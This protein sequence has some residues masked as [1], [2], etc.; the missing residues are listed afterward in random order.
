MVSVA[1]ISSPIKYPVVS[2][3][4]AQR[5][6]LSQARINMNRSMEGHILGPMPVHQ[7]LNDFLPLAANAPEQRSTR[8]KS[9]LFNLKAMP[10]VSLESEMYAPFI[11]IITKNKLIPGFKMVDTSNYVDLTSVNERRIKPDA[12]VYKIEVDTSKEKTQF[13]ELELHFELKPDDSSDPFR[14]PPKNVVDRRKWEFDRPTSDRRKNCRSQ[15]IHYV[16]DWSAHQ[17]RLFAFTVFLFDPYIRFIRWDRAGAIVSE[18]FNFRKD[19]Q[20]LIDFLW[21]FTQLDPASRGRDPTVRPATEDEIKLAKENLSEWAPQKE[22]PV[23]VFNVPS[24]ADLDASTS[25][26]SREFIGWGTMSD[27]HSLVG[28]GTRTYPV[29]EKA[30]KTR[31]FIKDAWRA[32]DLDP[33]SSILRELKAAGVENIPGYI[34]GSDIS[35]DTTQTDL[36]VPFSHEPDDTEASLAGDNGDQ[37]EVSARR[38]TTWLCGHEWDKIIRRIHHRMVTDVIGKPLKTFASSKHMMQVVSDAFT[39]HRQ[40]YEKCTYIHRDISS[41]NVIICMKTNKGILNDWDLAKKEDDIAHRRHERT[42]T[43]EFMS[44]LILL[45]KQPYHL[46]QDDMES[47]FHLVLYHALRYLPHNQAHRTATIMDQLFN[48]QQVAEEHVTGG[49]NKRSM[50]ASTAYVKELTFV[51]KPLNI[52]LDTCLDIFHEWLERVDPPRATN[53]VWIQSSPQTPQSSLPQSPQTSLPQ[54]PQPSLPQLPQPSLPQSPQPSLPQTSLAH[55]KPEISPLS[56][57]PL[58]SHRAMSHVFKNAL[59]YQDWP[60][61]EKIE[62]ILQARFRAKRP[63]ASSFDSEVTTSTS[64]QGCTAGSSKK[65]IRVSDTP[66]PRSQIG[67]TD[68]SSKKISSKKTTTSHRTALPSVHSMSTRHRK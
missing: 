10:E 51:S 29:Y 61:E 14:D 45:N 15:L 49:E 36:Y 57:L 42:G 52:W 38:N 26:S 37:A 5:V 59:A 33:E 48:Q 22:R 40:A 54:S 11:E 65:R 27:P 1:N 66:I 9:N 67:V 18:R 43:W 44:C 63:R 19:S 62:D 12:S 47:F 35:D 24:D 16:I 55:P 64:A 8:P 31:F 39:A 53:R 6:S 20:P 30:T 4:E 2:H 28:R 56:Q 7:F 60:T 50:F 58:A 17:H 41:Q 32:H 3:L 68:H 46:I 21:R 23:V 25:T 34:C 13:R